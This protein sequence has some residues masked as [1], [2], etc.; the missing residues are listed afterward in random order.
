MA[1]VIN[2]V[3]NNIGFTPQAGSTA[4]VAEA[5]ICVTLLGMELVD[6][7]TTVM[8]IATIFQEAQD[9]VQ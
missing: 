5:T 9:L 7:N 1:C 3:T 6:K 4:T 8:R 2:F